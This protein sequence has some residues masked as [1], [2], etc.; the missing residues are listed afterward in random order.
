MKLINFQLISDIFFPIIICLV[1]LQTIS[2]APVSK[3]KQVER[4]PLPLQACLKHDFGNVEVPEFA[5]VNTIISH[6]TEISIWLT[7]AST[8]WH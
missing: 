8:E 1:F 5:T 4:P 3:W 6:M 2:Q 7:L